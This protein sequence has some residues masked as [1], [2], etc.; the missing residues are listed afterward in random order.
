MFDSL[1]LLPADPILGLMQQ[2]RDDPATH[3]V[4]LGVGIYKDDANQ[5]PVMQAV[6]SAELTLIQSQHSKAYVAP[7]GN[8]AF[9][10]H[11]L[12]LSLAEP[13]ADILEEPLAVTSQEPSAVISEEP[14]A[15]TSE[16]PSAAAL[17]KA[18]TVSLPEPLR[19]RIAAVQTP[20]GCGALRVAAELV[21]AASPAATLWV[22]NPTWGNHIPLLGGAGLQVKEYAY[23]ADDRRTLDWPAMQESIQQAKAGDIVLLHACCHN[24]TGVDLARAHWAWL[25]QAAVEQGF[26]PFVDM[27]YQGFGD[28]LAQDS[29]GLRLLVDKVPELLLAVSCSKNFGLYRER[30]GLVACVSS[31][32]QAARATQ[33]HLL[34][35]VRGIYSMPPD[36]GAAIVASILGHSELRTLWSQELQAMCGRIN[37]LR[38]TFAEAMAALG[39]P[40][41]AFITQQKGM[42]SYL[43]ISPQQVD[44][45]AKQKSI[46]LLSSS[47]MSLAGLNHD[48]LSYVTESIRDALK[49]V[50]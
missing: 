42:F 20:G 9:I 16:K 47:R 2:F 44:W 33:S 49:T 1:S 14:L 45:L 7:Q 5:T 4:D 40:Q 34:S 46:Y 37:G 21:K 36:H 43:G 30:V 38:H 25:A 26:I 17:E 8:A 39:Q 10:E 27:A 6:K 11:I 19:S 41:F 48:N 31:C 22:S 32:A 35:I 24:P 13:P 50:P 23:L 3:K 18:L 15:V 28:G 12:S 29:Q